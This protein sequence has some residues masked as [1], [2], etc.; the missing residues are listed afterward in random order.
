VAG[1]LSAQPREKA[2]WAVVVTNPS[3]SLEPERL[4][5]TGVKKRSDEA[6]NRKSEIPVL[7]FDIVL[8]FVASNFEFLCPQLC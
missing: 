6:R 3:N 2:F 5:R 8:N 1:A 4:Y 7:V